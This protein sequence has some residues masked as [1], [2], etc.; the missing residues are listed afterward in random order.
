VTSITRI[1]MSTLAMFLFERGSFLRLMT[2]WFALWGSALVLLSAA[3]HFIILILQD[4][5]AKMPGT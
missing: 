4:M 2:G 5:F 3:L 1:G